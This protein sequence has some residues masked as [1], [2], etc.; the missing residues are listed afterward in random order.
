MMLLPN[1]VSYAVQVVVLLAVGLVAPRLLGLRAPAVSL[2]YW[3]VLLAVVL[4]LPLLQ[5]WQEPA[6]GSVTVQAVGAVV[7]ESVAAAVPAAFPGRATSWLL[8][9]VAVVAVLRLL[10]IGFGLWTLRRMRRAARRIEW[11]PEAV[12]GIQ[13]RLGVGA[14]LMESNHVRVPVT[15]GWLR[16]VVLLPARFGGL[17]EAQQT[18]VVCH[19]LLHVRRS[20]WLTG[21]VE[22]IARALLWFH[23]AV[24]ILLGRISLSR[25]QLID[26]EVVRITGNRRSYLDALWS[27][28]R[29]GERPVAVPSLPLLNRSDLFERVAVLTEEVKM[30]KSRVA[31]T[32]VAVIASVAVA[33]AAVASAFPLVK[34]ATMVALSVPEE[35]K[36]SKKSS[37]K[38]SDPQT[39]R[40][41]PDGDVTEPKAGE[42]V[43]FKYPEE[44]R[45]AGVTGVV[46]CETIITAEG[47]ISDIKIVR[48]PDEVFN[49][50]TI[51]ALKQWRFEPATLDGEPV[52]V[53]YLLTVKYN[54]SKDK[55]KDDD[56]TS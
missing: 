13:R 52:D 2:R 54:L 33:G 40:F 46:V 7:T 53:I 35:E 49:Q 26:A 22:H 9:I 23:P 11:V 12:A 8:G 21:L 30:S 17:P 10:W 51:D 55:P 56:N 43:N 1:L 28:A 24:S 48:S 36:S 42:K 32:A 19:E 5:P 34:S 20:D 47:K 27:V 38:A 29:R 45:K 3:Q 18:G 4:V 25:E 31:A 44:A 50:P 37:E 15:F 14:E 41:D 39:I 16:P 6:Q